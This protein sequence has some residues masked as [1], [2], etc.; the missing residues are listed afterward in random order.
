MAKKIK[1][2]Y[3]KKKYVLEY[4]RDSIARMEDE[5]FVAMYMREKPFTMLPI[6]F[7]GAF[8][9]RNPEIEQSLVDEIYD[10]IKDK[11]GIISK[12]ELMV[13]EAIES[14]FD[15][16]ETNEGNIIWGTVE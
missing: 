16:P 15:E 9:A 5:G 10:Q 12:L 3:K 11:Q 8:Y 4:T 13:S 14:L 2:E 6:L 1:F 7:R